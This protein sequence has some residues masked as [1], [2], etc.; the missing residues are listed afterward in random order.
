MSAF[1]SPAGGV[2]PALQAAMQRRQGQPQA[3]ATAAVG[4][5]APTFDP[6]T[7]PTQATGQAP[8]APQPQVSQAKQP[9]DKDILI[10][11]ALS[12]K[13]NEKSVI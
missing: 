5:G 2:S 10:I 1:M 6:T 3:G 9:S 8:G 7:Q 13:L 4:G 11:K 12:T